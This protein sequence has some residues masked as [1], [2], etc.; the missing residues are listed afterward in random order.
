MI[1]SF[2]ISKIHARLKAE[3]FELIIAKLYVFCQPRYGH[4]RTHILLKE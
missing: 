3:H 2:R 4:T 1:P